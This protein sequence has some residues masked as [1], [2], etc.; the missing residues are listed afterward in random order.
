MRKKETPNITVSNVKLAA[1]VSVEELGIL[2]KRF[3]RS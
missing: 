3:L 1:T 2:H